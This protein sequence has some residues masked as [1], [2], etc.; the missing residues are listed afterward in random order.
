M[1][2]SIILT[3][4]ALQRRQHLGQMISATADPILLRKIS[5][6]SSHDCMITITLNFKM[7]LEQ[8]GSN[9]RTWLNRS[10]GCQ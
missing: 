2:I 10:K 6:E 3:Y 8:N 5:P 7:A 1:P 4:Y 9:L